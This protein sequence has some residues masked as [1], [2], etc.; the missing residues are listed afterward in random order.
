MLPLLL[1]DIYCILVF[2]EGYNI[3]SV[4]SKLLTALSPCSQVRYV[5]SSG[6]A[7]RKNVLGPRISHGG[8]DQGIF[9]RLPII[10]IDCSY[11]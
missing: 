1:A 6:E 5:I 9:C 2:K 10:K 3:D 8:E 11:P 7:Q 4:L